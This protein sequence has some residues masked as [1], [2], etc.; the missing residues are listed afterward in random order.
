[1]IQRVGTSILPPAS[2]SDL[3]GAGGLA[4]IDLAAMT[5]A[6]P[7][8]TPAHSAGMSTG[9]G[10]FGGSGGGA[11]AAPP[12]AIVPVT[13]AYAVP[14]SAASGG[15]T[16]VDPLVK[17]APWAIG[18]AILGGFVAYQMRKSAP[19]G[20]VAGAVAG[21]GGA[22]GYLWYRNKPQQIG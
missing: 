14:A 12:A 2:G 17:I 4:R 16:Y 11:V 10:A 9:L 13:R 5:I 8:V 20:A 15:A 21:A 19:V 6:P 7:A 1:M 22:Y 18:G 3:L